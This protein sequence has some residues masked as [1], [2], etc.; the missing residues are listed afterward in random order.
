M[1]AIADSKRLFK[2]YVSKH[3]MTILRDDEQY[4]HIR[5]KSP[6]SSIGWF[7]LVTWPYHLVISGD[8]ESF[9]FSREED[10]FAFFEMCGDEH[11]I[12]PG[13]WGEKI[14]GTSPFRTHSPEL[15]TQLV[16]EYFWARRH[17]YRGNV[18]ELWRAIREEVLENAD[19]QTPARDALMGF[20]HWDRDADDFT[21]DDA[22]EWNYT[23][24]DFHYLKSLHAI[25]WG[26]QQYRAATPDQNQNP[27]DNP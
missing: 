17:D 15:F 21:F 2:T 13:Y 20:R 22:W 4:R 18:V 5:F 1:S 7:D 25:V 24:Y 23:D 27:A 12:N 19:Y 8:F 11:G 9:H 14:Q 3:E 16:V 10:M 26:I 6:S